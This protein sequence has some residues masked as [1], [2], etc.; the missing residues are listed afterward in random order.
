[1]TITR[2]TFPTVVTN[3]TTHTRLTPTVHTIERSTRA[4]HATRQLTTNTSTILLAIARR[5]TVHHTTHTGTGTK[6]RARKLTHITHKIIHTTTKRTVLIV[7]THATI[8]T[9]RTRKLTVIPSIVQIILVPLTHHLAVQTHA[10]IRTMPAR[11]TTQRDMIDDLTVLVRLCL[12]A[13]HVAV[14]TEIVRLA[15]TRAVQRRHGC[16]LHAIH[17]P[18]LILTLTTVNGIRRT[19]RRNTI[20]LPH[21]THQTTIT[22]IHHLTMITA[23]RLDTHALII[24]VRTHST[25]I[26][27]LIYSIRQQLHAHGNQHHQQRGDD[28]ADGA[29]T[30]FLSAHFRATHPLNRNSKRP[31]EQARA[32]QKSTNHAS[33]A[34]CHILY[35]RE[36]HDN[37]E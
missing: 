30:Y 29:E 19:R 34:H 7:V 1:M 5:R 21:T 24:H 17:T 2:R 8:A 36:N 20:H 12:L 14:Q 10:A 3:T 37:A 11:N 9:I 31:P 26:Q 28:A 35:T 6:Q 13:Q 23:I 25:R 22:T 4:A 32:Q 27:H 18:K 16:T 33:K 15:D